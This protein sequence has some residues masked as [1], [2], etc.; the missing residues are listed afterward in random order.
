MTTRT[1]TSRLYTFSAY[2]LFECV[3]LA[4]A[5]HDPKAKSGYRERKISPGSGL[6]LHVLGVKGEWAVADLCGGAF[7]QETGSGIREGRWGVLLDDGRT[8]KVRV[9]K[10]PSGTLMMPEGQPLEADLAVLC[11][12]LAPGILEGGLE[13]AGYVTKEVWE[14]KKVEAAGAPQPSWTVAN[15]HLRPV[16]ELMQEVGS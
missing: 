3:R 1:P 14:A 7:R 2:A 13:I 15:E 10:S 11:R 9:T 4:R 6:W 8:I 12:E 5:R 16:A